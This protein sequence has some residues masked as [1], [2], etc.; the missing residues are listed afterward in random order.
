M[1]VFSLNIYKFVYLCEQSVSRY[2]YLLT[3]CKLSKAALNNSLRSKQVLS[4]GIRDRWIIAQFIKG[5][6]F[7]LFKK[8]KE[9]YRIKIY[10]I[11]SILY[12]TETNIYLLLLSFSLKYLVY[13]FLV[14]CKTDIQKN[15]CL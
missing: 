7:F 10:R 3:D 13:T 12:T 8:G 1:F 4:T 14:F 9:F 2:P 11:E 6:C 5:I 15:I